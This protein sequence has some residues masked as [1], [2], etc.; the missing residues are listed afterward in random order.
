MRSL[1]LVASIITAGA[2]VCSAGAASPNAGE[3][4]VERGK[5]VVVLEIRGSVLGRL[6]AGTL[7][8]I[9]TTPRDP[10]AALVTG[11]R[12]TFERLGPRVIL[13]RGLGLRFR[14]VGG[15]YRI[16]ARGT[17]ISISAV[18][19]GFVTLDGE[20]KLPTDDAGVYSLEGA[21]CGLEPEL[22]TPLPD[23]LERFVLEP[24][25]EEGDVRR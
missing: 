19:R 6:T 3:L 12:V 25:P 9:D 7:R 23:E 10:Y 1:T 11:R 24:F 15:G 17:G 8:V 22:C 14:M 2:I 5:G 20:R 21:D 13:Y 4:S 18:G 16:V